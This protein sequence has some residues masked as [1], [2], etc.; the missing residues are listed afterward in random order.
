MRQCVRFFQWENGNVAAA[1][2]RESTAKGFNLKL[3]DLS[4]FS[5][6]IGVPP[7]GATVK[8]CSLL[9]SV[10]NGVALHRFISPITTGDYYYFCSSSDCAES[11]NDMIKKSEYRIGPS[12]RFVPLTPSQNYTDTSPQMARRAG[13][14]RRRAKRYL[15]LGAC[16]ILSSLTKE[17]AG[18]STTRN[19]ERHL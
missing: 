8:T 19:S 18:R 14:F 9:S 10:P 16:L 15:R 7:L 6:P 1:A 17:S 4:W 5:F 2:A 11:D 12:A 13:F 3:R